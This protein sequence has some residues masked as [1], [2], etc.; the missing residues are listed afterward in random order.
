MASGDGIEENG[1]AGGATAITGLEVTEIRTGWIYTLLKEDLVKKMEKFGLSS[2]DTVE[3]LRRRLRN[4]LREGVVPDLNVLNQVRKWNVTF[5][6]KADAVAF[7]ERVEELADSYQIPNG[8]L[9]RA[10]PEMLRKQVSLWYRNNKQQWNSWYDFLADFKSYYFPTEFHDD[11]EEEISR[12]MQHENESGKD[13]LVHM[14]TLIRKH[15][16]YSKE[17]ELKSAE[18]PLKEPLSRKSTEENICWRCGQTGNLRYGCR[19]PEEIFCSRC[20]KDGVKSTE[21]TC[22]SRQKPETNPRQSTSLRGQSD[23]SYSSIGTVDATIDSTSENSIVVD[24]RMKLSL[25]IADKEFIALVDP[26]SVRSYLSNDAVLGMDFARKQ[27]LVI[28]LA[29][30]EIRL[31]NQILL[32][33]DPAPYRLIPECDALEPTSPNKV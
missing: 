33:E 4:F 17:R 9:L 15:G 29:K 1:I 24:N 3:E 22:Q 11:L 2:E 30:Q 7:I 23:S 5:D 27:E 12:R 10:L 14:Q 31:G 18:N 25:R 6:G 21:G 13:F 16:R 20:G 28:D 8:Q 19:L 32:K 26:G